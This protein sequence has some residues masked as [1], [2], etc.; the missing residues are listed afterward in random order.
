MRTY[1]ESASDA[2]T[3]ADFAYRQVLS[4]KLDRLPEAETSDSESSAE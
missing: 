3:D 4:L 2:L 1:Y